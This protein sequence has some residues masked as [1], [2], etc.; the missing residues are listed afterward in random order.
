MT[1]TMADFNDNIIQEMDRDELI[2]L[3]SHY[4]D[5]EMDANHLIYYRGEVIDA[6]QHLN[7]NLNFEHLADRHYRDKRSVIYRVTSELIDKYRKP[8]VEEEAGS[9]I[10]T[11]IPKNIIANYNANEDTT[12]L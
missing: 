11:S 4:R 12:K 9:Q 10:N 2:N 1:F 7:S 3:L 6:L 5:L 8:P